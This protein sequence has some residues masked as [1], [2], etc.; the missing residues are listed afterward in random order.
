[1]LVLQA[2]VLED[3]VS[4][5][6]ASQT[7]IP[8]GLVFPRRPRLITLRPVPLQSSARFHLPQD[9]YTTDCTPPGLT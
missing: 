4:G 7:L 3:P 5:L 8:N 6:F 2:R 1:M 9:L